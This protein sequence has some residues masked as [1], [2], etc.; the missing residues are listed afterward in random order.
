MTKCEERNLEQK[1]TQA[2]DMT[3][4]NA[5]RA[6]K[7]ASVNETVRG[8]KSVE[9]HGMQGLDMAHQNAL[10]SPRV[11]VVNNEVRVPVSSVGEVV[12]RS[13]AGEV[14][15]EDERAVDN[16]DDNGNENGT[17]IDQTEE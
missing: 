3:T 5:M 2:I 16:G 14:T 6:P 12:N 7:L 15:I 13:D 11:G 10:K 17:S 8:D 4:A 1:N 9:Y